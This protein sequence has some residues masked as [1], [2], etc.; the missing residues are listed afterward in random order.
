MEKRAGWRSTPG[1]LAALCVFALAALLGVAA[2]PVTA[3]AEETVVAHSVDKAGN[4]TD[5]TS[6]AAAKTAGYGGA[7]IYMDADW[8]LGS[9]KLEIA[10]SKSITI[11]M[12]GHKITSSSSGATV[13][14][15]ENATVKIASSAKPIKF[16]YR[17]RVLAKGEWDDFEVIASGLI[18]NCKDGKGNGTGVY[19]NGNATVTLDNVAVAGAGDNGIFVKEKSTVNLVNATVCHNNGADG[20]GVNMES[21]TKL[22]M[23]ASHVDE[24]EGS[25]GGGLFISSGS[26]V[27]VEN[28]STISRNT[29]AAGGGIYCYKSDFTIKSEDGTGVIAS[30][31]STAYRGEASDRGKSGGGIHVDSTSGENEGL[32]EGLTIKDNYS[33]YDGGGIELDQRWTTVRGCTITGNY[34]KRDGGGIFVYGGNNIVENCT[35]TD[36]YCAAA[37]DNYEGGGIF[38]SYH[39]DVKLSG[40][41]I[42]KNNARGKDSGNADDVFLG[43][44]SGGSGKAYIT[45]NL[46]E[47]SSVGVRTGVSG[48]RRIA[49]NFSYPASKD[50]LFADQYSYHI[51]YGT[52]E[53]GDAWQRNGAASL[54]V[55]VNGG[56]S[57]KYAVGS[58]ATLNAP[59]SESGK[60]FWYWDADATKGLDSA[61][62]YINDS[63]KFSPALTF[64][65][66]RN[67]VDLSAVYADDVTKAAIDIQVPQGGE[68][69]PATASFSRA[70]GKSSGAAGKA[71]A[72]VAWYE[73]VD[74]KKVASAGRAWPGTTYVAVVSVPQSTV[75]GRFFSTG[76]GAGDVTSQN[77]KVESAKVDAS[78]G[79]LIVEI[80][81]LT[82][83]GEVKATNEGKVTV[84][85]EK[86]DLLDSGEAEAAHALDADGQGGDSKSL[87]QLDVKYTYNEATDKV[88]ITAPNIEGYNFCNWVA[89][90]E[91]TRD[92]VDGVVVVPASEL[93]KIETL[94]AV[95]TP[96]ITELEV[97]LHAPVANGNLD[98]ACS[99]VKA[100]CFDSTSLDFAALL[101]KE[102]DFAVTW[103][104][105][106]ENSKAGYSTSYTAMIE[107]LNGGAGTLSEVEKVISPNASIKTAD[108]VEASAAGFV[109]SDG[110]LYLC[111]TFPATPDVKVTGVE[112][113]ADVEL[114]FDE[115]AAY[116]AEQ[117]THPDTLCW[118]LAGT[119]SVMLEN[120]EV[121]DGDIAWETPAGFNAEATSAQ[122]I[123]VKGTVRVAYPGELD[124]SEVTLD[125]S[126][127]IKVA[128]PEQGGDDKKDDAKDDDATDDEKPDESA[129]SDESGKSDGAE[130]NEGQ[131]NCKSASTVTTTVTKAAAKKG[132]PSTG[133]VTFTAAGALLVVSA[134][135]LA[136]A[137]FSRRNQR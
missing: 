58:T 46:S 8:D 105:V 108:G 30:N 25:W 134:A 43:T 31:K 32:I 3:M 110:K 10:D 77:G 36:N 17:G 91:W 45:G 39:Y 111:V 126:A 21:N 47:G 90:Y 106:G 16:I 40:K 62:K 73:V 98:T 61:E 121:V 127:A 107:I 95:Y 68:L 136:A 41:C 66:A 89:P 35:I 2:H 71:S 132:T 13:Y 83:T 9:D 55:R 128:A 118:P 119:V 52:D 14:I 130:T 23:N 42:I 1:L 5:Y 18:T 75:D 114:T 82:A 7:T 131:A 19:V 4:R 133:D 102:D 103:S 60:T 87:G 64:T 69:F 65:M 15:N 115:A 72:T 137:T 96:V 99:S 123:P 109:V 129:K 54:A 67:D 28:G 93:A 12:C 33:A 85:L 37:G 125:V 88:T 101:E 24:N 50:C 56:S 76:I 84:Q 113:P 117:A 104:P 63:T 49:K 44:V 94:T 20:G 92:D 51:S 38:V 97:G 59:N 29:A 124:D 135:C 26:I 80:S 79:T 86:Q 112:L 6:V 27:K 120:G 70:D 122:E 48:E 57:T 11:D 74:G 22:F 116:A 78:T 81:G 53:G 100:N 34:A